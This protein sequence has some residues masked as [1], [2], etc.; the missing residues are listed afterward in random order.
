MLQT[1][2]L[3]PHSTVM[4]G[5]RAHDV[6]GAVANGVLP[7]GV[8]WGYGSREELTAAGATVLC[9]QP[10]MLTALLQSRAM[11]RAPAHPLR[12]ARPPA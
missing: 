5:D 9:E 10:V 6:R 1:E 12:L 4:V 3:S 11:D 2:S 7:I 8:L